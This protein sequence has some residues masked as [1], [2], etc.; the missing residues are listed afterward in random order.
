MPRDRG[1]AGQYVLDAVIE[2]GEQ[3]ALMILGASA[4]GDV[5]AGADRLCGPPCLV[6]IIPVPGFDPPDLSVA[7][8]PEYTDKL[9]LPICEGPVELGN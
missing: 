5:D 2:L 8:N 9:G 3:Q 4:L 6:V 7:E 1:D